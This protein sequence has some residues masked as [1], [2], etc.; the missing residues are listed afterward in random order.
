MRIRL[1]KTSMGKG[2]KK[3][4]E[5]WR[6][7]HASF[8]IWPNLLLLL[9]NSAPAQEEVFHASVSRILSKQR[10]WPS[11]GPKGLKSW[12]FKHCVLGE[13]HDKLDQSLG[14][15]AATSVTPR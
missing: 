10:S 15:D 9:T 14:F 13:G 1:R 4:R 8:P 2:R 5:Q 6:E 7:E 11:R 12:R 3:K